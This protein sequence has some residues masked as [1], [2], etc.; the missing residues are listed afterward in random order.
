M[1]GEDERGGSRGDLEVKRLFHFSEYLT[2]KSTSDYS[3]KQT[4]WLFNDQPCEC[5][6]V[7][8]SRKIGR[9][10]KMGWGKIL[11]PAMIAGH[12]CQIWRHGSDFIYT[13]NSARPG[14]G[15]YLHKE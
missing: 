3:Q 2:T 5:A 8:H 10:A 13:K 4:S 1:A 11:L 12:G 6:D 14:S 15:F 7:G 9:A